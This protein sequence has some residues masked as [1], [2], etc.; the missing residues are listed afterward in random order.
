MG[1][2]NC[3]PAAVICR[4]VSAVRFHLVHVAREPATSSTTRVAVL[5]NR[6]S[7]T[8]AA[9][10]IPA[11][12]VSPLARFRAHWVGSVPRTALACDLPVRDGGRQ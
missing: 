8:S 11:G 1:L 7:G 9:R 4:M 3:H 6:R 12:S 2:V 5:T 10:S